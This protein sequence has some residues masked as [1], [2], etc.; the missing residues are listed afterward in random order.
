MRDEIL[1]QGN[2]IAWPD[3][4]YN[5]AQSRPQ[6]HVILYCATYGHSNIE[7]RAFRVMGTLRTGREYP[8]EIELRAQRKL[9]GRSVNQSCSATLMA[10]CLYPVTLQL[11]IYRLHSTGPSLLRPYNISAL[12]FRDDPTL[13]HTRISSHLTPLHTI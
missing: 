6:S 1:G 9:I 10:A 5:T 3:E 13:L 4:L 11:I 8:A 2:T 7:R 12:S